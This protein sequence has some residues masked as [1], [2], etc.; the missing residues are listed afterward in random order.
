MNPTFPTFLGNRKSQAQLEIKTPSK[1]FY[2][3]KYEFIS[4]S[5]PSSA[6][7]F[8]FFYKS[9]L[10]NWHFTYFICGFYKSPLLIT[11][12]GGRRKGIG[13]AGP[14]HVLPAQQVSLRSL[15][16]INNSPPKKQE[17]V[18]A[19]SDSTKCPHGVEGLCHN[20][21]S[22]EKRPECEAGSGRG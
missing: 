3:I 16:L 20:E 13:T 12:W 8:F 15:L 7:F 14:C 21:T 2:I 22:G 1:K 9:F 10:Q 17:V 5:S 4:S 11:S 19:R 18:I 6:L